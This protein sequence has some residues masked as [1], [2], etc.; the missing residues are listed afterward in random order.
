MK[1]PFEVPVEKQIRLIVNT[2]AKCEADDQ[3]AIVHAVLTPRFQIKGF[4]G[5]HFGTRSES[6]MEQSYGEVNKVLEIMGLKEEFNVYHGSPMAIPDT[7][8]P[9]PSEGSE[10][11]IREA[12]KD[13]A[14][15]LY[16][17]F[18]GPLTDLATAYLQEPRIADRLT[19]IWI[20]GGTYPDGAGEFNL[21]NDI[22]AANVVF[23]SPIPLWQVPKN[24]YSMI[25]VSLA[26]LAVKVRPH[27][28]IGKYLYDQLVE[29]NM[30]N[31]HR[32]SWPK[33][34][35]WMLGDSPAVSLLLDDHMFD[36]DWVEAPTID[37]DMKY[38]HHSDNR[39]IRVYRYVDSRF[40]LEDFY[41][42]LTL[43]NRVENGTK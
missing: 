11:I 19:V 21:S 42:K 26:E 29:H 32:P 37:E 41:A 14:L 17:I 28:A 4:I 30:A 25:R 27:G 39:P 8:T 7:H 16:V 24:V 10:L 12:M 20:G 22:H 35:M 40:T 9:I 3:Y 23:R 6:S 36:Y 31:G 18:L 34:E 15:P 33:G 43:F 5:A 13:D 38:T 2:D 1:M